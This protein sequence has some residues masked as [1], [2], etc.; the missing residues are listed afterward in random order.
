MKLFETKM[1]IRSISTNKDIIPKG[2]LMRNL[3]YISKHD[4]AINFSARFLSVI[5]LAGIVIIGGIAT[6]SAAPSTTASDS[7]STTTSN[8]AKSAAAAAL[9]ATQQQHLQTI[10]SKGDSEISRRLTSLSTLST[11]INDATKLSSSDKASLS[12]EVSSTTAGLTTLKTQLDSEAS[13]TPV[14][15]ALT[16][17]KTD[18]SNI[19]SEYR[20]YALVLPKVELVKVADD[21]QAVQAKLTNLSQKLQTRITADQKAGKNVATIQSEETDM[22]NQITSAQTISSNIESNVINLQ[23]SDYNSNHS[24]LSGD[25]TQLKTAH[26]DDQNAETDAKNIVATLKTL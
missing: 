22:T 6:A 9:S 10:I 16:A 8:T 4:K 21:Q 11:K 15:A 26:T 13:V 25:N 2:A 23:P 19:Y 7:T 24:V 1:Y 14:S 5:L 18:V 17:A 20:V 12:N 3:N